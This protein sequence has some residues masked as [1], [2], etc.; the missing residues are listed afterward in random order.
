MLFPDYYGSSNAIDVVPTYL[1]WQCKNSLFSLLEKLALELLH[2][3][4]IIYIKDYSVTLVCFEFFN[5]ILILFYK[6]VYFAGCI[7]PQE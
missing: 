2:T 5:R 3:L 1:L 6:V 4:A 7:M